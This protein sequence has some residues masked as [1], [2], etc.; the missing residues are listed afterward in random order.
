MSDKS[1]RDLKFPTPKYKL[2]Q[3]VSFSEDGIGDDLHYDKIIEIKVMLTEEGGSVEY[4]LSNH[5]DSIGEQSIV[6]VLG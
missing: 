3:V 6:E 1:K 2:G 4:Q 5:D